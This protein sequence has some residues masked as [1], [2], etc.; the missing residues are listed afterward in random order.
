[1]ALHSVDNKAIE[2]IMISSSSSAAL[3][4]QF[5]AI[6]VIHVSANWQRPNAN[7]SKPHLPFCHSM[8][9]KLNP[10]CPC[11]IRSAPVFTF[12]FPL[13]NSLLESWLFHVLHS[14]AQI[15][16]LLVGKLNVCKLS[17][18]STQQTSDFYRGYICIDSKWLQ[19]KAVCICRDQNEK[20]TLYS[21]R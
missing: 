17:G 4:T 6:F 18:C 3:C 21:R 1:M 16:A 7:I 2:K 19:S 12:Q 11:S 5:A 13:F 20:C 8:K 15:T 14:I 9:G 10:Y